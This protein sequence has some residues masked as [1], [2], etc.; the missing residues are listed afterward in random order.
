MMPFLGDFSTRQFILK[1][2]EREGNIFKWRFNIKTLIHQYENV[3]GD[4][5]LGIPFMK[6]VLFLKGNQSLY[7]KSED[8]AVIKRLFP[9]AI[10]SEIDKAGHWLHAENPKAFTE[11]ILKFVND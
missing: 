1:S 6:D 4:I 5:D 8:E 3:I 7:I 10:L 9:K 2:L 11:S